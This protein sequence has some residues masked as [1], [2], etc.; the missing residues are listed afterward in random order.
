MSIAPIA[1][2][3]QDYN[4]WVDGQMRGLIGRESFYSTIKKRVDR[5]KIIKAKCKTKTILKFLKKNIL[6]KVFVFCKN[7]L[8]NFDNNR[9]I[10]SRLKKIK[11]IDIVNGEML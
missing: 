6:K 2:W 1:K 8:N 10:L 4:M 3:L 7:S 5:Y 11:Y 9:I